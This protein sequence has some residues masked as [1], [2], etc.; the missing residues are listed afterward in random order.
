MKHQVNSD[1]R[2]FDQYRDL[3]GL[4]PGVGQDRVK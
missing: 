1:S 4:D 3:H 2:V